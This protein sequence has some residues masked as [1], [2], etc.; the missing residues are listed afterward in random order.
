MAEKKRN[1]TVP[2]VYLKS[3]AIPRK[4]KHYLFAY[5]KKQDT[6]FQSEI[7]NLSVER[8]FY[9]AEILENPVAIENYYCDYVEKPLAGLLPPIIKRA[10]LNVLRLESPVITLKEKARLSFQ[11][12]YQLTRGRVARSF[13]EGI[14]PEIIQETEGQSIFALSDQSILN[15]REQIRRITANQ[16]EIKFAMME[17]SIDPRRI[18]RIAEHLYNRCWILYRIDGDAEFITSDNPVM[19]AFHSDATPFKHGLA[20][21][22]TVVYY[23]I[24]ERLLFTLYPYDYLGKASESLDFRLVP[25]SASREKRF[26][27]NVNQMQLK[28]CLIQAYAKSEK[29]IRSLVETAYPSLL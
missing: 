28:Q 24:S 5:D 8:D 6:V 4:K 17:A 18:Q 1:H 12:S 15:L 22:T 3:F 9:R 11:I 10:T 21:N 14:A 19:L 27:N 13:L 2:E 26:I 29:T 7:G 25:L 20:S 23:P 16:D